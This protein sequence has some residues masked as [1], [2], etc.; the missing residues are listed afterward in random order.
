MTRLMMKETAMLRRSVSWIA[1]AAILIGT[2]PAPLR[3]QPV[4]PP[5]E[6]TAPP[7]GQ[8]YNSEQVEAILAPVALY[9]DVLL[10]QILMASAFPLQVVEAYR[11]VQQGN[12][13]QI[14]GDRLVQALSGRNWDPSV[15][16]LVP[17]PG[18]LAQLNGN[19]DWLQQLGFAVA[20]QQEDVLDAVQRLRQRAYAAGTLQTNEQSVVRQEANVI[21]IEPP[22]AGVVYVPASN[23]TV[24]YGTWAYQ[25]YP[26]AY[27]QPEPAWG[28]NPVVGTALAFGAGIA[29]GAAIWGVGYPR[30]G[31]RNIYVDRRVYNN[32]NINRPPYRGQEVWR[33]HQAATFQHGGGQRYYNGNPPGPQGGPGRGG[34]W[35]NPP[36]PGGG[37][38]RG[39]GWSGQGNPPGAVGGPGRGPGWHGHNQPQ[40]GAGGG[41]PPGQQYRD[42]GAPGTPGNSGIVPPGQG[43]GHRQGQGHYQ[44]QGQGPGQGQNQGHRGNRG[45]DPSTGA[46]QGGGA[47]GGSPG[48]VP[49]GG[50]GGGASQ[51]WRSQQGTPPGGG[52]NY[53]QGGG[54]QYGGP[55]GGQGGGGGQNFR[56]QGGGQQY[57][58]PGGGGGGNPHG[59][60]GGQNFRQQSG[61]GGGGGHHGGG[62]GGGGGGGN[63]DRGGDRNQRHNNN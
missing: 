2:A 28:I 27:F 51:H 1:S 61:G 12:N 42:R 52:Q 46:Y 63:R 24:V 25:S 36:G 29:V 3:A 48:G 54:Q 60:G 39:P 50:Q 26:P 30:W 32:I 56:H 31:S 13:R 17:F 55:G 57:G 21:Y 40:G 41:M 62:G 19:L 7:A 44:G 4:L 59:G 9:P 53:R 33:P 15:K 8:G 47:P 23:P 14:Q 35:G 38:G 10:T 16:S 20:N 58:N 49:G 5:Q 45:G 34:N 11:W 43:Q 37:P 6:N 22:Q 18:V